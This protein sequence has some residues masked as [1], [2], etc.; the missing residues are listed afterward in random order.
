MTQQTTETR[1]CA[2]IAN[3]F[4]PVLAGRPVPL[5]AKLVS[6]LNLD[7]LDLVEMTMGCEDEFDIVIFDDES[8]AFADDDG[9]AG[10]TV[11]DVCDLVNR[12]LAAKA[13]AA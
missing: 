8:D 10:K 3:L 1:V 4:G 13:V 2:I 11:R 6:D 7:S 9:T 5:D 12:K